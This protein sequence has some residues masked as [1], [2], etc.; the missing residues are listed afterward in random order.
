[1]MTDAEYIIPDSSGAVVTY[2]GKSY[3]LAEDITY[4]ISYPDSPIEPHAQV[5]PRQGESW[6]ELYWYFDDEAALDT[7][8][9]ARDYSVGIH[10]LLTGEDG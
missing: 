4:R 5:V 10:G 1:M 2:G 6:A 8:Y 9:D 3:I 7:W